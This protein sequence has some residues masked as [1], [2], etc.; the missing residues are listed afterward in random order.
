MLPIIF[1]LHRLYRA[2]LYARTHVYIYVYARMRLYNAHFVFIARRWYHYRAARHVIPTC[3]SP[4]YLY[5]A[6]RSL[7]RREKCTLDAAKPPV[8]VYA[9]RI[10]A[11]R[12]QHTTH[13]MHVSHAYSGAC[14]R[15]VLWIRL[16]SLLMA[17]PHA[18]RGHVRTS[19]RYWSYLD[20][21]MYS[22]T[23]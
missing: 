10:H 13:S 5:G 12:T 7:P 15:Y 22:S 3:T 20:M 6:R 21:Y 14:A 23:I 19:H 9:T 1:Y 8:R 18:S 17:S 11:T 2:C 4:D 16:H